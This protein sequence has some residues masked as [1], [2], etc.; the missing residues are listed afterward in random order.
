[1]FYAYILQSILCPNQYYYGFTTNVWIRLRYHN[2]GRS[3]YTY[4]YKPWKLIFYAAFETE[5]LAKDFEKYLKS[6]SGRA[7]L[8]KR[9]IKIQAG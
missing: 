6:A 1:M 9:L 5:K 4:K 3:G 7:F 2:L 8:R